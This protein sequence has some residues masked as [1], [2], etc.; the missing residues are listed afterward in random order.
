MKWKRINDYTGLYML[1]CVLDEGFECYP[2]RTT[3][4][5]RPYCGYGYYIKSDFLIQMNYLVKYMTTLC[6]SCISL[7]T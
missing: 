7:P 2:I 6:C 4:D 3:L 1:I 5:Y